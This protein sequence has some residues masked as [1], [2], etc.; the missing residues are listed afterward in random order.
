MTSQNT[1]T[2]RLVKLISRGILNMFVTCFFVVDRYGSGERFDVEQ[3][4]TSA[5]AGAVGK[6]SEQSTL[7]YFPHIV[8]T[9]FLLR[10]QEHL[11]YSV[12]QQIVLQIRIYPTTK[13]QVTKIYSTP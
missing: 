13:K 3:N 7:A 4:I 1:I 10:S 6:K 11:R 12:Q 9:L 5:L 8:R 2:E